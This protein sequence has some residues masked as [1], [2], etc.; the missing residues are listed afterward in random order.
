MFGIVLPAFP[1]PVQQPT[2]KWHYEFGFRPITKL[3]VDGTG[4]RQGGESMDIQYDVAA[5]L[6]SGDKEKVVIKLLTKNE[7]RQ[8]VNKVRDQASVTFRSQAGESFIPVPVPLDFSIKYDSDST[9]TNLHETV[10]GLRVPVKTTFKLGAV[11]FSKSTFSFG[12]EAGERGGSGLAAGATS[13]IL[14]GVAECNV[15][16]SLP[17]DRFRLLY[18]NVLYFNTTSAA[19]RSDLHQTFGVQY[20]TYS[21]GNLEVSTVLKAVYG[22]K[23]PKFEPEAKTLLS[24]EFVYKS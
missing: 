11:D 24:L 2:P 12:V 1:L 17:G 6:K 13:K 9:S 8:G 4:Q 5:K 23:G 3:T 22:M 21:K 10:V 15:I 18:S 20:R 14:R 19:G 16:G 7:G